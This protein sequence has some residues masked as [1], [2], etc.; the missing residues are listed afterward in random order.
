L[1]AKVVEL[2][3]SANEVGVRPVDLRR[4]HCP[5]FRTV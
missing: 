1:K 4:E 3:S 2:E 5:A